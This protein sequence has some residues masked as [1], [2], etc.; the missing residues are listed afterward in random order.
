MRLDMKK[1]VLA[2][3]ALC[4]VSSAFAV[5]T[6]VQNEKVQEQLKSTTMEE[7]QEHMQA[8]EDKC[9]GMADPS[10]CKSAVKERRTTVHNARKEQ[11]QEKNS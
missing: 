3:A 5:T 1:L 10:K 4:M 6:A 7:K 8:A 2:F 11:V 9:A